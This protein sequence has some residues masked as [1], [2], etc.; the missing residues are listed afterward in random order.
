MK[1]ILLKLQYIANR[2]TVCVGKA[3]NN[4]YDI[5]VWY[6]VYCHTLE[7]PFVT[8]AFMK[9]LN[10]VSCCHV[11]LTCKLKHF[12]LLFLSVCVCDLLHIVKPEG[13]RVTNRL[14]HCIAV[15][16]EEAVCVPSIFHCQVKWMSPIQVCLLLQYGRRMQ[17]YYN[18]FHV[19]CS[20]I[21]PV[22]KINSASCH[23]PKTACNSFVNWLQTWEHGSKVSKTIRQ[24]N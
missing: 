18:T 12:I 19:I 4:Q 14:T 13:I 8:S 21:Q 2:F 11:N 6:E 1:Q 24:N 3:L 16:Q 10:L 7:S 22:N 23:P 9:L 15:Q 17:R 5:W 20:F